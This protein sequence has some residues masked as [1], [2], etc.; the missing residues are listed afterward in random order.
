[1]KSQRV[2][3]Q[4]TISCC[5]SGSEIHFSPVVSVK[6]RAETSHLN[7]ESPLTIELKSRAA[8]QN[9]GVVM[10]G[11][12][13]LVSRTN[14][15]NFPDQLVSE[16]QPLDSPVFTQRPL[17]SSLPH[18]LAPCVRR[19]HANCDNC[20]QQQCFPHIHL[21]VVVTISTL[22]PTYWFSIFGTVRPVLAHSR[23]HP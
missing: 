4:R 23:Q 16:Q 15:H 6:T 11:C 14:T 19:V 2:K 22:A 10:C 17:P 7:V 8:V 5:L 12:V 20:V 21:F 1:M 3:S 9:I 13:G 18:V